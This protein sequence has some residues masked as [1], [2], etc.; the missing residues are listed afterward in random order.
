MKKELKNGTLNQ[1]ANHKLAK[2]SIPKDAIKE[3][4]TKD[5]H[6]TLDTIKSMLQNDMY[7][8]EKINASFIKE[9]TN[10][11]FHLELEFEE[12]KQS[13][14]EQ[15]RHLSSLPSTRHRNERER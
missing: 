6:S 10:E 5:N 13:K 9:I 1:K 11:Y 4:P 14:E 15:T 12:Y 3:G 2:K 8:A 7:S